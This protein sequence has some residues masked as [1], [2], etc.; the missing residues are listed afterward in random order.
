MLSFLVF[1]SLVAS[2]VGQCSAA[3]HPPLRNI[4]FAF[5]V[6]TNNHSD[7]HLICTPVQ[8]SDLAAFYLA[9]FVAHAA[10]IKSLP[11]EPLVSNLVAM[12][13]ALLFPT[14]AVLR[15]M[16]AIWPMA[17]FKSTPL[18]K[19][20]SSGALC[21]V[22]EMPPD[23]TAQE[24]P[25]T[26]NDQP[27]INVSEA[28]ATDGSIVL[29]DFTNP[30]REAPKQV[31]RRATTI[32]DPFQNVRRIKG[33]KLQY[34]KRFPSLQIYLTPFHEKDFFKPVEGMFSLHGRKVHGICKLPPG[35]GLKLLPTGTPVYE[36]GQKYDD[37]RRDGN[38]GKKGLMRVIAGLNCLCLRLRSVCSKRKNNPH[39]EC[40]INSS[41]SFA[42]AAIAIFQTVYASFTLYRTRGDQL[43]RYGY[44]A[45]GLTVAPYVVMSVL[46]LICALVTPDYDHVYMIE[47]P[48]MDQ[49]RSKGG[50]FK[51]A[52]GSLKIRGA[53]SEASSVYRPSTSRR[54]SLV[55]VPHPNGALPEPTSGPTPGPTPVPMLGPTPV[56]VPVATPKEG[57]T[58]RAST[59]AAVENRHG[60]AEELPIPRVS[61]DSEVSGA[62]GTLQI[63]TDP[64]GLHHSIS[65]LT[66][67]TQDLEQTE[68]EAKN[69]KIKQATGLFFA[70][71]LVGCLAIAIIGGISRF[72][73]G[74]STKGQRIWT[75]MWFTFGTTIGPIPL[76]RVLATVRDGT[77][78]YWI[79]DVI[80]AVFC[81]PAIGG[82]IVVGKMLQEYGRC[83]RIY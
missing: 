44:A 18:K 68:K 67:G 1:L 3:P 63:P 27:A 74:H 31:V 2:L 57:G 64:H 46:N 55:L 14:S 77:R 20:S 78:Y 69:H 30:R 26:N 4:T 41:Y 75:M 79:V 61:V 72:K 54:A 10:T 82:Y 36:R 17:I 13:L 19:A 62:V 48:L 43:R 5:P 16:F 83:I 28:E 21:V 7:K 52:V 58:P 35:Y 49:A 34:W 12:V 32:T 11:G 25:N 39:P 66:P 33:A 45:F 80:L 60:S 24:E 15:A 81:A 9:N 73:A 59:G 50:D 22:V 47:S 8:K 70:S 29:T 23:E 40:A 65:P 6:G 51:G 38:P 42:K 56:P 53:V 76:L 37:P 71:I